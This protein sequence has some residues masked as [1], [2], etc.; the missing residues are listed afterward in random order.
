MKSKIS[1]AVVGAFV[2]GALGLAMVALLSFGGVN[3]FVK[4]QR[5]MVFFHES[6]HGLDLGSPV[7]LRGVRVGRVVDLQVRYDP[8]ANEP[9]AVVVCELNRNT[10]RDAEGASMDVSEPGRLQVLVDRGLRA[11][12]EVSGW[13]T[14]LLFIELDFRNP[15]DF[16]VEPQLAG[17]PY[18]VVPAVPSLVAGIQNNVS[19]ILGKL[20]EVDFQGLSENLKALL[21]DTRQRLD[22]VDLKGLVAQWRETGA[23]VEAV[24][25][26]PEIPK[27][28]ANANDA[29]VQLRTV[30]SGL[31]RQVG[32]NGEDLRVTLARTQETLRDFDAA[33]L[34]LRNF[35][36]AQ[37]HIGADTSQALDH[38]SDAADAVQ[39]LAEFLDRNPN[40][41]IAGR[42]PPP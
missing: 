38:L 4:P 35:I 9:V 8:K 37:Q 19:K 22:G 5:F 23:A 18:P 21:V 1:P 28:L 41:L 13:A 10:I 42:K 34:T 25:K 32:A 36:Q 15:A 2:L 31:D 20:D 33:A 6:I 14:G 27:A 26:S 40:A 30:L 3:L 17:E 16:P 39:R 7:K 11:D 12:L 29:L 24:A